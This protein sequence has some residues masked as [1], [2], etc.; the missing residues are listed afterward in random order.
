[1]EIF[2]LGIALKDT[3]L[4]RPY[5]RLS[6]FIFVRSRLPSNFIAVGFKSSIGSHLNSIHQ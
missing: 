3:R 1:M 4:V 2:R 6:G 5:L